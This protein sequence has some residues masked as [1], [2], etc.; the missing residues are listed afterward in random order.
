MVLP[1]TQLAL[2]G[3]LRTRIFFT[4]LILKKVVQAA[5][6]NEVLKIYFKRG[7]PVT[8]LLTILPTD[9]MSISEN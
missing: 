5:R 2:F 9:K 7:P 4:V 8:T 6:V 3:E 1:T